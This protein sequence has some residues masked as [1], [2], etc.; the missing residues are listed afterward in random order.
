MS[1]DHDLKFRRVPH[2]GRPYEDGPPYFD[3]LAGG[4]VY[5]DDGR[6]TPTLSTDMKSFH[7]PTKRSLVTSTPA[8]AH[9][10]S[11]PS[12]VA[13]GQDFELSLDQRTWL[14]FTAA[15]LKRLWR[16]VEH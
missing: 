14:P 3:Q 12:S 2:T 7:Q 15:N 16:Q 4:G 6:G 9:R 10:A 11:D 5:F 1:S 13:S 8:G